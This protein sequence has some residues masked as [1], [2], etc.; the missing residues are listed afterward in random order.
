[1]ARF[2]RAWLLVAAFIAVAG[3]R[4]L[5]QPLPAMPSPTY[6]DPGAI[7]QQPVVPGPVLDKPSPVQ[8]ESSLP[9]A[10]L[11]KPLREPAAR[12]NLDA[13]DIRT[14]RASEYDS[15]RSTSY[16]DPDSA[17][18]N[19]SD[20]LDYLTDGRYRKGESGRPS[21]SL[22]DDDEPKSRSKKDGEP[23]FGE[24]L[25]TR[26]Q[27]MMGGHSVD[28]DR[29]WFQSEQVLCDF[30][31]PLSNPFYFEDPR[32]L[33]EIRPIVMW[34]QIPS[35]QPS[36]RGGNAWFFGLQGRLAITDRFSL[37]VNKLGVQTFNPGDGSSLS[38]GASI[39]ELW[40]GPKYNFYRDAD[41]HALISAGLQF[42]VP[43]GGGAFQNTPGASIVPYVS[44]AKRLLFTELGTFNGMAT[45]G[46]SFATKNERSNYFFS[47]AHLDFDIGNGHR[48]FPLME[49]NWF[50]YTRSGNAN[51]GFPDEGR[52][53]ANF[54]AGASGT[55]SL[56][57]TLGMRWRSL[58]KRWEIGGGFEFPLFGQR[59]ILQNRVTFDFI[60]KF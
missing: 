18:K 35:G 11:T 8:S 14:V 54:G 36:F 20:G 60:W 26:I 27:E 15:A 53:L 4:A 22:W 52:D 24:R 33:T 34:Q 51:P 30:I 50:S 2:R 46:F 7:L 17:R 55:N 37:V 31:S 32:T 48:F 41:N 47:S 43:L 28:G 58:N 19:V 40:F 5:G 6:P 56:S 38:N 25:G 16:S 59:G 39:T 45:T 49:L 9:I 12:I 3:V 29:K 1:M 42:Q 57:G 44:A 10:A 13:T 21:R 23:G